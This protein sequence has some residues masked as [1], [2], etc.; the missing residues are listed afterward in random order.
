VQELTYL[1]FDVLL[2]RAE[3]GTYRARVFN[4][5]A[6]QTAPVTF[7][8]PLSPLEIE[9]FLLRVGRPRHGT[10]RRVDQPETAAIKAF[11][12]QLFDAL[13]RDD[14]HD[15]MLRSVSEASHQGSGLRI[16]LRLADCPELAELPWEFLYD[17]QRNRFLSL[18]HHTPLI[19]YL[20]LPDPPRPL[21]VDVPLRVLTMIASPNGYLRLDVEQEWSKL[22]EALG[23]LEQAG[24]VRLERLESATLSALQRRLRRGEYHIFHF[25]GHGGFD[26]QRQDGVLVCEDGT[27]QEHRVSGEEL[28]ALLNDHGPMRLVVLNACEGA[29]SGT[30]DPFS[31]TAQSLVQQGLPAVIAMQFEI[32]DQ[33]A[34]IFSHE[35]YAAV[36]VIAER[37][38]ALAAHRRA[39]HLR[40]AGADHHVGG[41]VGWRL[42]EVDAWLADR[43]GR[44][45]LVE[46][47]HHEVG[48]A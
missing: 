9:N 29:R 30:T 23:D 24:R 19:R 36:A 32:T 33:A 21:A 13:F 42:A 28:G 18:S 2:E 44:L 35:L 45:F 7:R 37:R 15:G 10:A 20:E 6:G 14:L 27:G 34:I 48:P 46:A 25:I 4:A 5:P 22:H 31:G 47:A 40:L 12:G 3:E 38:L 8:L 43:D 26:P 16:R 39:V 41:S 11:G 1:D 17:R